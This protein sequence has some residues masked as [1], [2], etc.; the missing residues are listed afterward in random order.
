MASVRKQFYLVEQLGPKQSMTPEGFLLCEDVPIARPGV[1]FYGPDET[2]IEANKDGL[3]RIMREAEDFFSP[4]TIASYHGKSVVDDHPNEDVTP[5]NWKELT[6]G[7]CMNPRRGTGGYHDLLLADLL[8]TTEDAIR[9]VKSGKREVSCG[10]EADY[11]EVQDGVGRQRNIIGN[12]IALVEQ[13]RCGARC[14]IND[15]QTVPPITNRKENTM[16][17]KKKA[18]VLDMLMKAFKAKDASEVEELA[19][20]VGDDLS[21]GEQEIHI[22]LNGE[23]A[24]ATPSVDEDL[25]SAQSQDLDPDLEARLAS[26]ESGAQAILTKLEEIISGMSG[27]TGDEEGDLVTAEEIEQSLK[28]EAPEGLEEQAAKANDSAYMANS[29]KDT[30]A[31]AEILSPGFTAPAF[32]RAS[33]PAATLKAVCGLRRQAL[34]KAY[35]NAETRDMINTVL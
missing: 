3:V 10:Y 14:A 16:A 13:G 23:G 21:N 29:F 5:L 12:H 17:A 33:A 4:E 7:V 6:V 9:A 27:K 28:D 30:L 26:L 18:S 2:P 22:H 24:A 31:L 34:D 8:I 32:G 25:G 19:Q 35:E 15:K 20:Q 1:M 11:E